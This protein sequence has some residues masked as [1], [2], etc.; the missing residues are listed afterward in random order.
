MFDWFSSK[1][2]AEYILAFAIVDGDCRE[3]ELL[4]TPRCQPQTI[5]YT[6]VIKKTRKQCAY[7]ANTPIIQM[8]I[9]GDPNYKGKWVIPSCQTYDRQTRLKITHY[10]NGI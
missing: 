3:H 9:E 4:K 8:L 10:V 5:E 6:D 2:V 1:T 7:I